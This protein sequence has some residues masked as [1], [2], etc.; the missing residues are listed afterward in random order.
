MQVLHQ[1]DIYTML[2]CPVVQISA[3]DAAF[4]CFIY[5]ND[6]KYK[7]LKCYVVV[8]L[9]LW[10]WVQVRILKSCD[11]NRNSDCDLRSCVALLRDRL[12]LGYINNI[13]TLLFNQRKFQISLVHVKFCHSFRI[14]QNGFLWFWLLF[15]FSVSILE[16]CRNNECLDSSCLWY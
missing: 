14:F 13:R 2:N 6:I 7:V 3:L 8:K 4:V 5:T 9:S 11:V 1:L 10:S 12:Y 15:R 16:H